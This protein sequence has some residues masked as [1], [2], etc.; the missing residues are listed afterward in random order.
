MFFFMGRKC[1]VFMDKETLYSVVVL[2]VLKKDL[3]DPSAAF[4]RFLT[5]QLHKDFGP[6]RVTE[7]V[8]R[9][10]FSNAVFLPTDNDR[11]VMGCI[12]DVMQRIKF[13]DYMD[14]PRSSAQSHIDS[15]L[16]KTPIGVRE[17]RF[18]SELMRRKLVRMGAIQ[19][20][21]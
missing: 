3:A 12:N 19:D 1:L 5:G 16:N 11:S 8:I 6:G 4:V 7:E 2:D 21:P 20:T 14:D 13:Y 9:D 15:N 10:Y 18:S 17:F